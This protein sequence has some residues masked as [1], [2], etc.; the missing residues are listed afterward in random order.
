MLAERA[1]GAEPTRRNR[2]KTRHRSRS[3]HA[4]GVQGSHADSLRMDKSNPPIPRTR[5]S[6]GFTRVRAA[7]PADVITAVVAS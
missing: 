7:A 3:G 5:R 1:L 2:S 4:P 6:S